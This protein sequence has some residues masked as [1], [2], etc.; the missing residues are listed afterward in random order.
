MKVSPI[1]QN[2]RVKIR[3]IV[4]VKSSGV[5]IYPVKLVGLRNNKIFVISVPKSCYTVINMY[6]Y[7]HTHL[8]IYIYIYKHMQIHTHTHIHTYTHAYTYTFIHIHMNTNSQIQIHTYTYT[9]K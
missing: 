1:Q 7:I 8:Y 6:K 3:Y 5:L 9:Y 4:Q 2:M